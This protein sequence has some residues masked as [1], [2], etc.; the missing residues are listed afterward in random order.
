MRVWLCQPAL[1]DSRLA[2]DAPLLSV[3]ATPQ[4][5]PRDWCYATC[6]EQTLGSG[7]WAVHGGECPDGLTETRGAEDFVQV[8]TDLGHGLATSRAH[9]PHA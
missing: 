5:N 3:N 6:S 1:V 8:D 7:S 9:A 4:P 2:G